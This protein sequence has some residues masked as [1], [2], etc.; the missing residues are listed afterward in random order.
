M[1]AKKQR[2]IVGFSALLVLSLFFTLFA[3]NLAE[4][5]SRQYL[6]PGVYSTVPQ[7]VESKTLSFIA[8]GSILSLLSGYG[9]V[10]LLIER[11]KREAISLPK[12]KN[13]EE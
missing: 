4:R 2:W 8:V 7:E 11:E 12:Q 5:T 6:E 9:L 10:R 1:S 3:G 13:S